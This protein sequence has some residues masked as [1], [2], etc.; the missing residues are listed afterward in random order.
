MPNKPKPILLTEKFNEPHFQ[1]VESDRKKLPNGVLLVME[2][3]FGTYDLENY[4]GRE[5]PRRLW[6]SVIHNEELNQKITDK[7]LMG[8]ADH[9][10]I[11][12]TSMT[13]V[14]HCIRKIWLEEDGRVMGRLDVLDTPAGRIVDTL[15]RYGAQVGIS[16]RGAGDLVMK[17]GRSVVDPET[18]EYITHDLVIDPACAGSYPQMVMES[19]ARSDLNETAVQ[20]DFKFYNQLFE[21]LGVN[22]Q[23][24]N[25]DIHPKGTPLKE[26]EIVK[27]KGLKEEDYIPPTEEIPVQ[28]PIDT[29]LPVESLSS[30]PVQG[31]VPDVTV[32]GFITIG[33]GQD[34]KSEFSL[35]SEYGWE[36]WG[37]IR[38]RLGITVPLVEAFHK[39][40]LKYTQSEFTESLKRSLKET[41]ESFYTKTTTGFVIQSFDPRS[42][43][44]ISQEFVAGDQE[45]WEDSEGIALDDPPDADFPFDMMQP[46][47]R[48]KPPM[49]TGESQT[50]LQ[51]QIRTLSQGIVDLNKQLENKSTEHEQ[52]TTMISVLENTR[53]A[54]Q[55]RCDDLE[56]KNK[57]IENKY[58]KTQVSTES[59]QK[60]LDRKNTI[61]RSR[62]KRSKNEADEL[63]SLKRKLEASTKLVSSL[64]GNVKKRTIENRRLQTQNQSIQDR[65]EK[66]VNDAKNES[67]KAK[68]RSRLLREEIETLRSTATNLR[69]ENALVVASVTEAT[70]KPFMERNKIEW[71]ES[72]VRQGL[73]LYHEDNKQVFN[74]G[75]TVQIHEDSSNQ[76]ANISRITAVLDRLN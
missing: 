18:Y 48:S 60:E 73:A 50:F 37:A 70:L 52:F 41:G 14:S 9:P 72:G 45:E 44:F 29:E 25:E 49:N 55:D 59:L 40:L 51:K 58:S 62:A 57:V 10:E 42:G 64:R 30:E 68:N 20:K 24:L 19:I 27:R 61:M 8:E 39:D 5:Y 71:N 32:E 47:H 28:D 7:G 75:V 35:T 65:I 53:N 34:A 46:M 16:S 6:E 67:T 31:D 22:L 54:L 4:N 56:R 15:A 2:G 69:I 38:Q 26:R 43:D 13:R 23:K 66:D 21:K 76:S 12:E 74:E 17:E 3:Q 33:Q 1:F 63:V 11:L 36:Q